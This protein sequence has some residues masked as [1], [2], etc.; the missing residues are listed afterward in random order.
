MC[1]RDS[2]HNAQQALKRMLKGEQVIF[3]YDVNDKHPEGWFW[4]IGISR[5]VRPKFRKQRKNPA[6]R[7]TTLDLSGKNTKVKITDSDLLLRKNANQKVVRVGDHPILARALLNSPSTGP[8][9]K[10]QYSL[11]PSQLY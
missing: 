11:H 5:S 9:I 3:T 8:E 6:R 1:I 7:K 4:K 2:N 10:R